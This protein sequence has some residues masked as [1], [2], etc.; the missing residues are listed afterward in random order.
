MAYNYGY[1]AHGTALNGLMKY[2]Q[3]NHL[4]FY[5]SIKKWGDL[6]IHLKA[7]RLEQEPS[8]LASKLVE[9]NSKYISKN[10]T[11][12]VVKKYFEKITI[13]N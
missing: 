9:V 1:K 11:F 3:K 10:Y 8:K 4:D 12:E 7:I 2:L 13:K 6:N 5:K